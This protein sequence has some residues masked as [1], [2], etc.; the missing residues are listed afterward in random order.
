MGADLVLASGST[1]R[2]QMLKNAGYDFDVIPASIDEEK[3]INALIEKKEN[4]KNISKFLANEKAKSVSKKHPD[5]YI[6]SSDQ[7][8][9]MNDKI[10]S[11]VKNNIEAK[12]RLSFFQG[13]THKLNSAVSVY[14]NE[15]EVFSFSDEASLEMKQM[16]ESEIE[17]YCHKT[18]D[19]LT[20][21]VGCYA[22]E[23]LGIRLFQEIEGDYFT[24]LGMP[25]LP[26]IQFLDSEGFKL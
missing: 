9:Y 24:I 2:Q 19:I 22:L 15:E 7:V 23:G 6:V 13:K 11:K 21:C 12:D 17:N 8:L 1:A 26:L 20:S 14:K 5:K 16:S 10:Y 3:I 18:G 4:I 25:L